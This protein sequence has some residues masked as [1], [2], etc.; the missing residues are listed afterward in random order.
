MRDIDFLRWRWLAAGVSLLVIASGL[1][2]AARHGGLELGIDFSGG[3]NLVVRFERPV[4]VQDVRGVAT[5]VAGASVVQRYGDPGEHTMLIRLPPGGPA[6]D[7]ALDAGVTAV[8][9]ALQRGDLGAFAVVAREL[10]GPTVGLELQRRG[11]NAFL[12]ALGGVLVY[13][14]YR[15]RLRFAVGAVIAVAHDI[16]VTLAVLTWFGAD[17]SLNVVA[18]MLTV[19]GYSVNDSI[20]VFDRVRENL[21]RSRRDGLATVVNAS[22]NQTLRRT[23]IT[24][25][26]TVFAALALLVAGGEVLWGFALTLL[27]GVVSGTYSTIF[28][29]PAVA[30]PF[31]GATSAGP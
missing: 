16:L 2:V 30:V 1:V 9:T 6:T 11:R 31:R 3:T 15:F 24:S 29:A 14:A 12:G 4:R 8:V 23:I 26:T 20:V 18:A 7:A 22:L 27:V 17:L 21:R 13:T 25:G 5:R 10:V 19:V 28:I